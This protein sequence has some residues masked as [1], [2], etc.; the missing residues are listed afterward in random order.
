MSNLPQKDKQVKSHSN[1]DEIDVFGLL[2]MLWKK[3]GSTLNQLGFFL[4]LGM[5][6]LRGF[7]LKNFGKLLGAGMAGLLFALALAW[8]STLKPDFKSSA[9]VH[10]EFLR[11]YNFTTEIEKLNDYCKEGN[12]TVLSQL[13]KL[14]E[15]QVH[16]LKGVAS[17]PFRGQVTANPE[18][19]YYDSLVQVVN[20]TTNRFVVTIHLKTERPDVKAIQ[21]GLLEYLKNN[22]DLKRQYSMHRRALELTRNKITAELNNFD[23]LKVLIQ[24]SLLLNDINNPSRARASLDISV[25]ENKNILNDPLAVYE[26][27]FSYFEDLVAIE[28]EL[29]YGEEVQLVSEFGEV[30]SNNI[31]HLVKY[32]INGGL[33]GTGL[34]I[35]LYLLLRL[36]K[37]LG[38][39]EMKHARKQPTGTA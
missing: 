29:M 16:M 24:K 30:K 36:N 31:A 21:A 19:P 35:L 4:L 3:A 15:D 1:Q 32:M 9:V 22:P 23:S 25:R 33:I 34:F 13:F 12:Y 8:T 17:E 14:P 6:K 37:F 39:F 18:S 10:S 26:K 27:D 20:A 5:A 28:N 38:S 2:G 7:L 11:G